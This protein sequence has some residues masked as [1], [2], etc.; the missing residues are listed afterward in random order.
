MYKFKLIKARVSLFSVIDGFLYAIDE[1]NRILIF[2][3]LVF[4]KGFKLNFPKNNPDDKTVKIS[5]NARFLA[6]ASGREVGVWDLN[7]KRK[8]SKNEFNFDIYAL[9]FEEEDY[10]ACG[11]YEGKIYYVNLESGETVAEIAKHKDF[12]QDIEYCEGYL[13]AGCYDKCVMFVNPHTLYKKERYI[14]TKPVKKIGYK[15]YLVSA[16]QISHVIKWNTSKQTSKDSVSFYKKFRDF[17]IDGDFLILLS[18]SRV[19]IYD[20]KEEV[21]LTDNF[22]QVKDADKVVVYDRYMIVSDRHGFLYAR[23]LFEEEKDILEYLK[24]EDFEK[25]Y[26]LIDKNPYLLKSKAYERVKRLEELMLKRA[27]LL[28][29]KDET[30]AVHILQKL[31]KV[32]P[33]REKIKKIMNDFKNIRLF[34]NAVNSKNYPLA[35]SLLKQYEELKQ[36]RFYKK[37]L[38]EWEKT[39]KTAQKLLKNNKFEAKELLN[40]FLGTPYGG[41]IEIMIE[42]TDEYFEFLEAVKKRDYEKISEMTAKY[43]D[44][45]KS[46]EYENILKYANMLK[47]LMDR[48]L[49]E[50]KYQKAKKAALILEKIPEF[51]NEAKDYLNK[52]AIIEKFEKLIEKNL[53]EAL[54]LAEMYEFLRELPSYRKIKE[55]FSKAIKE[56]EKVVKKDREKAKEILKKYSNID[57]YKARISSIGL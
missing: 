56:A 47:N 53:D 39:Y 51:Q 30:K 24:I 55:E 14:H 18:E 12:I 31:L 15:E 38:L 8:V 50:G 16:D 33:L 11:G 13:V 29:E 45:K 2:N 3:S 5:K 17:W 43:P 52:I 54:K 28:Y 36:S 6:I 22:A 44:L 42:K 35:F 23:N 25:I 20:L 19:M 26:E 32:P 34:I 41:L 10:L 49:K 27:L 48:F 37:L 7:T 9:G 4:L 57:A 46:P 40:P 1:K 21:I